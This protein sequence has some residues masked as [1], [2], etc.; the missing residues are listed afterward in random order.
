MR[1][2]EPQKRFMKSKA[3]KRKECPVFRGFLKYFPDAS[4]YVSHLS[5]V[6][7]EQHNPGTEMHWDRSKS[8]DEADAL[9]R[10]LLEYDK[11]DD[12][13]ILHAGKVAWRGMALLQKELEKRGLAE[14]SKYNEHS[15][16]N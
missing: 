13:G 12:D 6:A 10:H 4:L 15:T 7:N 3:Q 8:K 14:L 9:V 2:I 16:N 1:K 11:M 5:F